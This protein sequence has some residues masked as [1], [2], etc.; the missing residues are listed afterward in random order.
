MPQNM[1][2]QARWQGDLR[3][4]QCFIKPSVKSPALAESKDTLALAIKPTWMTGQ[5]GNQDRRQMHTA[6][7]TVLCGRH[8]G[9]SVGKL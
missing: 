6:R 4:L 8:V 7:L 3:R 1:E 9:E 5:F 2:T